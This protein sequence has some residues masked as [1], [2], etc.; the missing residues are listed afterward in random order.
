M[1]LY[2]GNVFYALLYLDTKLD[3]T[4]YILNWNNPS[5]ASTSPFSTKDQTYPFKGDIDRYWYL[6]TW[7]R[8]REMGKTHSAKEIQE[9]WNGPSFS[10]Y[11]IPVGAVWNMVDPHLI[12]LG[13]QTI[14]YLVTG[15]QGFETPD[16]LPRTNFVLGPQGPLYYLSFPF[17]AGNP[18]VL[19]EP[20]INSTVNTVDSN[21]NTLGFGTD[22]LN[23]HFSSLPNV[24]FRG[25]FNLWKTPE[26]WGGSN[27]LGIALEPKKRYRPSWGFDITGKTEG[28]VLGLPYES[29][30]YADVKLASRF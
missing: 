1:L 27:T 24:A 4:N 7:L 19:F 28:Y 2:G 18:R 15:N 23:V 11:N 30:F 13:Y 17:T 12:W 8:K 26:K 25:S 29:G 9:E 6:S 14:R 21:D 22:V 10:Y 5:F 20:Y 3:I 16:F